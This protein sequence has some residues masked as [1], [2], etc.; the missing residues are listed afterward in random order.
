MERIYSSHPTTYPIGAMTNKRETSWGRQVLLQNRVFVGEGALAMAAAFDD[1]VNME[2]A[3]MRSIINVP[4]V[5]AG[6]SVAILN[7]GFAKEQ[8]AARDLAIAR[9]L[10]LAASAGF[11]A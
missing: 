3:G 11:A 6:R 5:I 4:I 2:K 10:A 8:L 7:F 9:L 1:Q